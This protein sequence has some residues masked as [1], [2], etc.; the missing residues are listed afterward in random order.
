MKTSTINIITSFAVLV[1]F[2]QA[3]AGD[4][5]VR[6]REHFDSHDPMI[7]LLVI[8]AAAHIVA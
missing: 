8:T 5:K 2:E 1:M 3:I 6:A 4:I 7:L